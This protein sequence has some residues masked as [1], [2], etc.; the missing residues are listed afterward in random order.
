MYT[1]DKYMA[2]LILIEEIKDAAQLFCNMACSVQINISRY[3][4]ITKF[5]YNIHTKFA[6]IYLK[7][8]VNFTRKI[9]CNHNVTDAHKMVCKI[10]KMG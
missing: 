4:D 10:F 2:E 1:I 5:K 3:K 9:F 7:L 6:C 8:W